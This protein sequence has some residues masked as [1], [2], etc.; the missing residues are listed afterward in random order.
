MLDFREEISL[1]FATVALD[2]LDQGMNVQFLVPVEFSRNTQ[3]WQR[4]H[5]CTT[6][7]VNKLETVKNLMSFKVNLHFFHGVLNVNWCDEFLYLS[8]F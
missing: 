2:L 4:W 8:Y 3:S 6:S 5:F 7:N 1:D